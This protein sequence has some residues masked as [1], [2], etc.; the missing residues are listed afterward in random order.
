[1]GKSPWNKGRQMS[2]DFREKCRIANEGKEIPSEIRQKISNTF[3]E[4]GINRGAS[5]PMSK[6][7]KCLETGKIY[8]T[9]SEAAKD[10]GV[11]VS[12][13]SK[14]VNGGNTIGIY[15]W[16]IYSVIKDNQ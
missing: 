2:D 3:K 11:S 5:N 14:C 4:K 1:M 12:T 8:D 10:A 7:V 16:E 13:V 9:L 6:K 15:H